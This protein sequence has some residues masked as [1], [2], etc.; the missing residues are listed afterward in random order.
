MTSPWS[1]KIRRMLAAELPIVFRMAMS[2]VFSITSSTSD[3]M[4]FSAATITIRPIVIDIAIFS[5]H[6]AEKSDLFMSAQSCGLVV[7]RRAAPGCR[8]DLL[9]GEELVHLD[10]DEVRAAAIEQP[11]GD[12]EVDVAVGVVELVE[13]EVEDADHPEARLPRQQAERR[14]R[15]LRRETSTLSPS[16]TPSFFASSLPRTIPGSAPCARRQR[17]QAARPHR[18]RDVGH[19]GLERPGRCP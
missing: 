15:A 17:V 16:R 4:M 18:A 13:P 8:G 1:M 2:R 3:A 9:R 12:A 19:A 7:G 11:L 5:S 6:S 10:L 14:E